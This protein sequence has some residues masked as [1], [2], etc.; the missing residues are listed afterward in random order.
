MP[1]KRSQDKTPIIQALN[2]SDEE[3]FI[4]KDNDLWA[5]SWFFNFY[6]CS[7]S[8]HDSLHSIYVDSHS[9]CVSWTSLYTI[10]Y[11]RQFT[12]ETIAI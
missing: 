2:V 6:D 4:T 5:S 11:K 1:Y 12:Y 10:Y 9:T 3:L 7:Y 8:I